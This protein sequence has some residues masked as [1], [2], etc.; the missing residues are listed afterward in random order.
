[1]SNNDNS[2]PKILAEINFKMGKKLG[3]GMFS[4]VKLATHSVTNEEVSIK[5]LEK[6]KISKIEDKERINREISI[7]KKVKHFNIAKLYA[8]IETK[9]TIFLIQEYI[10]GKELIE[11]LN[12]KGKLK[13]VEACKFFHQ[14]I[15]GLD[16]LHQ[17]GIAHRDFKPENIILTNDNQILKIID[18]GLSHTYK[19]GELLKTGCGSPCYVPPEMVKEE[20]YNGALSDIWSA[21]I[22]LYLMLCGKLPFYDDDNQILYEKILSG[23]YEVPDH[24]SDNA[25][26]ILSKII[27]IDPKKRIN[28]EGIKSHPWFNIINKNYLMH[29][30]INVDTDIIP[31]DEEII[32]K[33]EKM[34]LN[35]VEIRYNLLKNYHN[36][37]TTIYDLLLKQKMDKG[38]KSI[39]DMNS[40][41]FDQYIND[42][43]NKIIV[44]GKI[45]D[46]LKYRIGDNPQKENEVPDWPEYKY[47]DNNE[48]MVIG[49]TG[50]VIERLIKAGKFTYDEENMCLSRVTK[51]NISRLKNNDD[52]KFKTISSM[53]SDE[54]PRNRFRTISSKQVNANFNF[55]TIT[56]LQSDEIDKNNVTTIKNKE[57]ENKAQSPEIQKVKKNK[58]HF[59]DEN[60]N[61]NEEENEKK[62]KN[63]KKNKKEKKDKDKVKDKNEKKEENNNIIV[64]SP[65]KKSNLKKKEK[66]EKKVKREEDEDWYKEMEELIDIE[67]RRMSDT[68]T[69]NNTVIKKTLKEKKRNKKSKKDNDKNYK[70]YNNDDEDDDD[71]NLEV[72]LDIKKNS[73]FCLSTNPSKDQLKNVTAKK[74]E[75]SKINNNIKNNKET[76][77]TSR[78]KS[79][80]DLKKEIKNDLKN[81]INEI[82]KTETFTKKKPMINNNNNNNYNSKTAKTRKTVRKVKNVDESKNEKKRENSAD[83]NR[84]ADKKEKFKKINAIKNE[85]NKEEETERRNQ[86]AQKRKIKIKI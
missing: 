49:D 14:I 43:K 41:I 57:M 72:E 64:A 60:E 32:E 13:E 70:T 50:S 20:K 86:S 36:K 47:D 73:K 79:S 61:E 1:M 51:K 46:V 10:K 11:Y 15:S 35:K 52:D 83:K 65:K 48:K 3:E 28:F 66:E 68:T 29:K 63:E 26:D 71:E 78:F 16:Y 2:M 12:K 44:Y 85:I 62:E 18:F 9:L 31:I 45:K 7:M 19:K 74:K 22:I 33:M 17:C 53:Q 76:L 34:G 67:N 6:T 38:L 77:K 42:K 5:I 59:K 24:L 58:V 81:E 55:K 30:G 69:T 37:I 80:R 54:I 84:K 75:E 25:K 4:T 8:V 23:K 40:D 82:K 21:G 27:E 39:S 56:S